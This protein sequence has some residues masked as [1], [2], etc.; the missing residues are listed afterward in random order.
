MYQPNIYQPNI[1]Q[2]NIHLQ[3]KTFISQLKHLSAKWEHLSA[4]LRGGWRPKPSASRP[5]H[6]IGNHTGKR[7]YITLTMRVSDKSPQLAGPGRT[8]GR[9]FE[10]IVNAL[11]NYR[12][13]PTHSRSFNVRGAFAVLSFI[14]YPFIRIFIRGHNPQSYS[15]QTPA[16]RRREIFEF[17]IYELFETMLCTLSKKPII[18]SA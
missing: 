14:R 11:P 13:R 6:Y 10:T 17:K 8:G 3:N 7:A 12:Y 16:L 9:L 15:T 1:Y 2:P 5:N 18:A 4:K